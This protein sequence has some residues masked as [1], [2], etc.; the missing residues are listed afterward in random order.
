MG[1]AVFYMSAINTPGSA[2]LLGFPG[3]VG[4]EIKVQ[5]RALPGAAE[6]GQG[7]RCSDPSLLGVEWGL[8]SEA[9]ALGRGRRRCGCQESL[10]T[11]GSLS[12]SPVRWGWYT[13]ARLASLLAL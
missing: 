5:T 8:R 13:E 9:E 2:A 3:I 1:V 10:M 4:V 7:A 12:S 6:G 11:S